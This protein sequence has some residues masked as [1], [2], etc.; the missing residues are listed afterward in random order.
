[1][2]ITY[3]WVQPGTTM[4]LMSCPEEGIISV[5][6][7][8][9]MKTRSTGPC[10]WTPEATSAPT[11]ASFLARATRNYCQDPSRKDIKL[12]NSPDSKF[13]C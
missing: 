11:A 8:Y 13:S 4:K 3:F 9:I 1:M 10:L 2:F 12:G 6:K 5:T 7:L